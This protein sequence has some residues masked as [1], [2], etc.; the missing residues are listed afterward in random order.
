MNKV[1]IR[2]VCGVPTQ[3]PFSAEL[4]PG[5]IP[6]W[7]KQLSHHWTGISFADSLIIGIYVPHIRL[8]LGELAPK[9]LLPLM[10]IGH[11]SSGEVGTKGGRESGAF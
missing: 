11:L 1:K 9:S 10:W 8:K 5:L 4:F 7:D 3:Y 2:S 6:V